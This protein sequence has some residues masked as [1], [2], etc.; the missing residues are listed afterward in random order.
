MRSEHLIEVARVSA[1]LQARSRHPPP[2]MKKNE[3]RGIKAAPQTFP[4]FYRLA[5]LRASAD[6][7]FP[8]ILWDLPGDSASATILS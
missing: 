4:N 1:N 3:G 8:T 7:L 6:R 5:T 2:A